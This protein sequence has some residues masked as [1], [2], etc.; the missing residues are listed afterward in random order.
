MPP[1]GSGQHGTSWAAW[2]LMGSP[3]L[4]RALRS[5]RHGP[6]QSLPHTPWAGASLPAC[7]YPHQQRK[8]TVQPARQVRP[9]KYSFQAGGV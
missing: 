7:W 6:V 3:M 1:P 8:V 4:G 5:L 2:Q 9:L